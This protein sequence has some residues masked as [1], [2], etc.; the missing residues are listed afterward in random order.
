[1]GKVKLERR[2]R[3]EGSRGQYRKEGRVLWTRAFKKGDTEGESA[4]GKENIKWRQR[5][6]VKWAKR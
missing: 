6:R 4:G 5:E 3:K 1:M 2:H